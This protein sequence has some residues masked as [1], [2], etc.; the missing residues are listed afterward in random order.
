M[1]SNIKTYNSRDFRNAYFNASPE[2]NAW[3]EKS[4]EDFFCLR[5]EELVERVLKPIRPSREESHTLILV[6]E[7]SYTMKIGF[8]DY[9]IAPDTLVVIQAGAV[10][11]SEA[12]EKNI[13]GFTCH[14]HPNL[15]IGKFG[16]RSLISE[17]N[18]LDVG[19]EPI[20]HIPNASTRMALVNILNRLTAEF[21]SE[22][23]PN[24]DIVHSYLYALL[25]EVKIIS[26]HN[27]QVSQK[28]S[29]QITTYFRKLV[30]EKIKE[31]LKVADFAELM[32]ISP[33]H[34]NKSVKAI[35]TKSASDL[36]D[37]IRC[38]EIKYLLYQSNLA[39]SEIAYEM[40]YQD[41]SYFTR[42]FK[43]QENVSPTEFRKKIEKS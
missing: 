23:T 18:F 40:G 43:K 25:T 5:I 34:L 10:F 20:I 1:Q 16:N 21:K 19:N 30:H 3:F 29:Y 42:F 6:T 7:G 12:I 28:A 13:K 41:P 17:F 32:N 39:I 31:N 33:N 4:I 9:T 15:L 27:N 26:G 22:A 2:L 11:S 35:T 38:I 14:F 8:K 24:S 37:E 36:I